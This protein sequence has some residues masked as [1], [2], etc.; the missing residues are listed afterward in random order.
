MSTKYL[1]IKSAMDVSTG[2]VI[3]IHHV[4]YIKLSKIIMFHYRDG[5]GKLVL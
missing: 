5:Y 2:F 1:F 3:Q 4:V